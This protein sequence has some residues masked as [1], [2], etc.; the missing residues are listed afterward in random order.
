[1]IYWPLLDDRRSKP[2]TKRDLDADLTFYAALTDRRQGP[3]MAFSAYTAAA[4]QTRNTTS[5]LTFLR[6][7][8]VDNVRGAFCTWTENAAGGGAAQV[9]QTIYCDCDCRLLFSMQFLTGAGGFIA[10]LPA[11]FA[12][13]RR[14]HLLELE[15]WPL[16]PSSLA[17]ELTLRGVALGATK[18]TIA[19][20]NTTMRICTSALPIHISPIGIIVHPSVNNGCS[21][22][23]PHQRITI[24]LL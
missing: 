3:A 14:R 21:S 2:P 19:I 6:A 20:D 17:S 5:T 1:L 15:L 23:I 22:S 12:G 24:T 4:A 13:L 11:S 18:L 16:L 10:S 7:A 9:L 8:Y